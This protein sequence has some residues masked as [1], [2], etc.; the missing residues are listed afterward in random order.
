MGSPRI[1]PYNG[2]KEVSTTFPSVLAVDLF[3]VGLRSVCLFL[4]AIPPPCFSPP[5][6]LVQPSRIR[7]FSGLRGSRRPRPQI[8][9][10]PP[11]FPKVRLASTRELTPSSQ[12]RL[13]RPPLSTRCASMSFVFFCP[14]AGP[15]RRDF[16]EQ[17]LYPTLSYPL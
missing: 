7:I 11:P 4:K 3:T 16:F 9:P 8:D 17:T 5:H 14:C 6:P 1:P 13:V 2:T 12:P 15:A 10:S